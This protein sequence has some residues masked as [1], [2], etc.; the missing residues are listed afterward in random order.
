[1]PNCSWLYVAVV[2]F[3]A[4]GL[5]RILRWRVALLFYALV[6]VFLFPALACKEVSV[7]ADV[8]KG[9]PPWA[10]LHSNDWASLNGELNDLPLQIVPWAHQVRE[11]WKSLTVPLWNPA[12]GCGYPL[13][14]N[15]QSSAFSFIRVLALPLTLGHAM[16]AEAAMK[17]LIALTF[18]YLYCRRR[19]SETGSIIAAVSFGFSGFLVS[20]LHFPIATAACF[21]PAVLYAI[22]LLA[23]RATYKRFLFAVAIAVAIIFAGHP[24]TA[25]HLALLAVAYVLWIAAAT[26]PLL[27]ADDNIVILS[28]EDG[29]GSLNAE[30]LRI[31]RSFAVYAAQDDGVPPRVPTQSAMPPQSKK[32]FVLS[33]AAVAI[34]ALLLAAPYLAV[35]AETVPKSFRYHE[36]KAKPLSRVVGYGDWRCAVMLVQPH[37]F[38]RAP[39]EKPW[40]P[41]DTEP[42]SGYAGALAIAA[43]VA[44]FVD[45]IARRRFRS[46]ECFF[47]LAT[48]FVLGVML[49]WPVFSHVLHALLP[50]MAHARVRLIFALLISLQTAAMFYA[51][52]R[53]PALIGI[54]VV[55]ALL[56]VLLHRVHFP[57]D[58]WRATAVLTMIPSIVVL[59]LASI[60]ILTRNRIVCGALVA[61]IAFELFKAG[62][63]RNPFTPERLLYART[64]LIDALRELQSKEHAPFRIAGVGAVLFPNTNAVFGFEDIRV[65]DPMANQRYVDFMQLAGGLDMKN[66]YAWW[67][68]D[69]ELPSL[70]F[71]NVRY[72]A[73]YRD[74]VIRDRSRFQLVWKGDDGAIYENRNALPRFYAVRNVVA[75]FPRAAFRRRLRELSDFSQTALLDQLKLEN[76]RM[77][78]DFFRPRPSDSPLAKAT[79]VDATPTDYRLHVSA[80]RYSLVVSSVAWWPGWRVERN[81]QSIDPIRVNGSFLGLAVPPGEWDVRVWY[82]PASFRAGVAVSLLTLA[83]LA[84]IAIRRRAARQRLRF[85]AP[86]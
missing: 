62:R 72:I 2:Y 79:I 81:G 50:M 37:F 18:T 34:V 76:Q 56:L 45:V 67:E 60:A 9:M 51:A 4:V 82:A 55:S 40:A 5:T 71:L 85:A 43:W 46:V 86:A 73:A 14:A 70:D 65:H 13:L 68:K 66:Y 69:I 52:R 84:A 58:Y 36:L 61:A 63:D 59:A 57:D 44:T 74:T 78:D 26:P 54:T 30:R 33:L 6:L 80:P 38:G 16:S 15:G 20:W 32:H 8:L 22:D 10:Y 29:E 24:E 21:A 19:Y 77:H 64:P 48:L 83:S 17:L 42:L 31:R 47:A 11:S 3:I 41:A 49:N 1:V 23:E 75:V 7:A 35:V 27:S 28:C 25:A 12:A 53:K 39:L